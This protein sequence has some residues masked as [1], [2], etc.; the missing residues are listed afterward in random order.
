MIIYIYNN[1]SYDCISPYA[2]KRSKQS[3]PCRRTLQRRQ[4]GPP[5]LLLG[6][7]PL[8]WC[9][10]RD[11]A[12]GGEA[13]PTLW[14]RRGEDGH[15][16]AEYLQWCLGLWM[17]YVCFIIIIIVLLM[18]GYQFLLIVVFFSAFLIVIQCY[19]YYWLLIA[20]IS[21]DYYCSYS[22]WQ[23]LL[24]FFAVNHSYS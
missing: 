15:G 20:I 1:N 4:G 7:H 18:D 16:G 12:E 11:R 8:P 13:L 23:L 21:I 19:S 17:I 10:R 9:L 14:G 24:L 22:D 3:A 2:K 5:G 6:R